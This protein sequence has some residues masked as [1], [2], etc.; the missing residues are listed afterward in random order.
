MGLGLVL[1]RPVI[2]P[3][4]PPIYSRGQKKT[5]QHSG[6]RLPA[7]K[8]PYPCDRT[9]AASDGSSRKAACRG[10]LNQKRSRRILGAHIGDP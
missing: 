4:R 8:R 7:C 9:P 2:R 10:V 1:E 5:G 6:P 3:L